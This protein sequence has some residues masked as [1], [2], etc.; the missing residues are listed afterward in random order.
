MNAGSSNLPAGSFNLHA[1]SLLALI[2]ESYAFRKRG[3]MP[4]DVTESRHGEV[5]DSIGICSHQ[6]ESSKCKLTHRWSFADDIY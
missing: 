4:S 2:V 6:N 5:D 3:H 1:C